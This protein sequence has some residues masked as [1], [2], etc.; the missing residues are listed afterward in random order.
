MAHPVC[1]VLLTETALNLLPLDAPA[2]AGAMVDFWGVVRGTEDG[3]EITGIEYE[4]HRA[5]AE[6]Q[7]RVIAREGTE[8]FDLMQIIVRHRIGFVAVGEASLLV[9]VASG[10]RGEA[11]LASKWLVDKLKKRAPIWKHPSFKA[12]RAAAESNAVVVETTSSRP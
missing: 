7:L 1:E 12:V 2:K 3:S 10:H 9:R 6:H 8:R 4:A 11:F 5:M